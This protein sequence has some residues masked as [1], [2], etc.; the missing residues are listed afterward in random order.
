MNILGFISAILIIFSIITASMLHQHK[1]SSEIKKSIGGYYA[2]SELSEDALEKAFFK[3]LKNK[4]EE[5]VPPASP[6]PEKKT[7]PTTAKVEEIDDDEDDEDIKK[8]YECSTLNI[9]PLLSEGKDANKDSYDIFSQII[10]TFYSSLL[11]E[12]EQIALIDSLIKNASKIIQNKEEELVLEK[13]VLEDRFQR[14]WYQMQ[15]GSKFY[16]FEKK[17]GYPSIFEL[18]NIS[19]SEK[20]QKHICL[21][22]A[23]KEMLSSLFNE[24][25][26]DEILEVKKGLKPI[27][28]KQSSSSKLNENKSHKYITKED[29][30]L[31]LSKHNFHLKNNLKEHLAFSHNSHKKNPLLIICKDEKTK[32]SIKKKCD[33]K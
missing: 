20:K 6:A 14:A 31:I 16:N 3:S 9:L 15:K 32:I 18:I 22:K 33:L 2:A 30:D 13:I 29:L 23:S 17:I 8:I 1:D 24:K 27:D 4:K 7:T 5:K 10:K 28:Q 12:K 11:S 25:I 19:Q 21:Q 26:A